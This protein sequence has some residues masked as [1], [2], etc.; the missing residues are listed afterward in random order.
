MKNLLYYVTCISLFFSACDKAEEIPAYVYV[1]PFEL[2]T[3]AATEG[4]NTSKITEVWAYANNDALGAYKVPGEI[5]IPTSG[6][7]T[8]TLYAGVRN[9]GSSATPAIYFH[10]NRFDAT[11][12]LTAGKTDTLTPKIA[13]VPD[14]TFAWLEDF[15]TKNSLSYNVVSDS[16]NNFVLTK[17]DVKYGTT[18]GYFKVTDKSPY[19]AVTTKDVMKGIPSSERVYIEV[20]YKGTANL[21][22]ELAGNPVTGSKPL[23]VA[24][25]RGKDEWNKAYVNFRFRDYNTTEYP[26]FNF[27]FAADIPRD[28]DGKPTTTAAELRID[29]IK[30]IYPK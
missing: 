12:N 2:S 9:N 27:I 4:A 7:V 13:Y 26:S 16:L 23:E 3:N 29:N 24:T 19:V 22:V 1:K 18:C 21:Q 30:L 28:A 8:L 11:M 5:P 17:Q 6:N 15:E 14:I 10:Y 20:D 25:F